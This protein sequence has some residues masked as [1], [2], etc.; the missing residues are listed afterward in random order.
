MT[1]QPTYHWQFKEMKKTVARDAES[2][3]KGQFHRIL[4]NGNGRIGNAVK[5]FSRESIIDLGNRV[6]QFSHTALRASEVSAL[7]PPVN[8]RLRED[9]IELV[10]TNGA[11]I[12]PTQNVNDLSRLSKCFQKLRTTG[13]TGVKRCLSYCLSLASVLAI[14]AE[15]M[16]QPLPGRIASPVSVDAIAQTQTDQAPTAQSPTP[17]TIST[18]TGSA[19][20]RLL[21]FFNLNY[22]E[23]AG[24]AGFGSFGGFLPLFQTPGQ[25]VTFIDG[26][27]SVD[28]TG[29]FGGGLQAGYRALLNDSTIGGAYAGLDA[30]STG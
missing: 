21:P 9:E 6:G 30:R 15:A 27:V 26:R 18:E 4:W 2:D 25:N 5:S 28:N 13:T 3:V 22:N 12:I 7:I 10:A 23:G 24:F 8:R 14:S 29:D 1:V 17:E 11:A 16:A 20:L 19:A